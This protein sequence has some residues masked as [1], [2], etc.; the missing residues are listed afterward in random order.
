M[1]NRIEPD[2]AAQVR[3]A[4][5]TERELA[6]RLAVSVKWLQKMRLIGGGV[7]F[8]KIGSAVRYPIGEIEKFEAA[9]L[10]KSTSDPGR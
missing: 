4:Y 1:I 2:P 9:A 7:P 3:K 8:C 5:L 6:Q 10:R